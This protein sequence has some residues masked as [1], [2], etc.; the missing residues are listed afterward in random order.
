MSSSVGYFFQGEGV[1]PAAP[2]APAGAEEAAAADAAALLDL[3][4]RALLLRSRRGD[5]VPKWLQSSS[6]RA[7]KGLRGYVEAFKG[8]LEAH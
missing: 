5:R 2:G 6:S 1:G 8:S 4:Q 3:L 7:P